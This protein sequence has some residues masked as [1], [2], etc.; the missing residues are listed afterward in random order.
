MAQPKS[1]LPEI[2]TVPRLSTPQA[3]ENRAP[4]SP[5]FEQSRLYFE[6]RLRGQ[7]IGS[8]RE[9]SVKCPFHDDGT[10]SMSV[11]LE[12]GAWFCHACGIGGGLLDFERTLTGK[13]D[14][15]CWTAINATIGR[16]APKASKPKRG[17]IVA[18]Y[19][20]HNAAGKI[21]YQ[22]VRLA[23]P[24]R[25]QQRQPNGKG[26]WIWDMDSVARVL[27]N[28][29]A[30][31]RANVAL[32]AEGE[33]DALNLQK[34]AAEFADGN[35]SL[36]YAATCN[37][38][39]AGKWL[40]EYSPYL[41]GKKAFVFQDNDDPGRRHAQQVCANV[42]KYAQAV[43]LVELPGLPDQGD[44]SDYLQTHPAAELFEQ[45]R[46]AP[47]WTP[48]AE[49]KQESV[50]P[51]TGAE[52]IRRFEEIFKWYIVAP[53]GAP[54]IGAL[55]AFMTYSFKVFSW[56]GY[57][58]FHSP[59]ESC[60]KSR[61]ADI[62]GWASARP[63]I[64]VSITE[65]ALFRLITIYAPTVVIDEAEVL[66][67]EDETAKALRAVLHA[68]NAPDDGIIRCAPNTH[69]PE[70]FSPWCPKIFC[71]IGHL[72]RTLRSRT[73]GIG[74]QR[75]RASEQTK[76]FIRRKLQPELT[77]LGI[78]IATWVREHEA[79]ILRAYESLPEESFGE[80]GRENFA[81]L[82]AVL[83]I[84]DPDRLPEFHWARRRLTNANNADMEHDS[85]GIRLLLDIKKTFEERGV[86][87]L[88][89]TTLID[90]LVAIEES[91]WRE[92]S[93]DRPLSKMKLAS[94]L[95]PFNVYPG[96]MA[97]GKARGYRF[98]AFAECFASYIPP[99][100]VK[101]SETQYPCGSDAIFKV[102]GENPSD[103]LE[104]AVSPNSHAGSR[105][106][107]TLKAG[108]GGD[109]EF[110]LDETIF[111]N[112]AKAAPGENGN[113]GGGYEVLDI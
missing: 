100:D 16:D 25:F 87:E 19:D 32:I 91:P 9:A 23:E 96:Q 35:G 54:L 97:D 94:L 55:Y 81:P 59:L 37:I 69:K 34:A 110:P 26:G 111:T 61:A 67:G 78:E 63:E 29:P 101:V 49:A 82:E 89:S 112:P 109:A 41:A 22:A 71:A 28:L 73:I 62:V 53:K 60:G 50:V 47:V 83:T 65:A 48:P 39:G 4:F 102:S 3:S 43:H 92:W 86:E 1:T 90:A 51:A 38:G 68:G 8:R 31:V 17:R 44:V 46:A 80:R 88:A 18:T 15:E 105:H 20:Y 57:L 72:P 104:N 113:T 27:F 76:A 107:D 99:Q 12:R 36:S 74:M 13:P 66:S 5:T 77:A 21:V 84:A 93:K 11:N 45:M 108:M 42:S 2:A 40:D 56:I 10:A 58:C 33:K 14:V 70:R 7:R 52:L 24:K 98:S 75:K 85:I 106:L 95:R 30:L 64:L 6:A 103:T 79:E